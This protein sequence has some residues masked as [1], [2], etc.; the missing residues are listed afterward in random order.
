M[1]IIAAIAGC[2]IWAEEYGDSM[3]GK[4]ARR[5]P[6]KIELKR[7]A[8]DILEVAGGLYWYALYV[9]PQKEFVAQ[10]ILERYGVTTYVPV[11]R[12]WRRRNKYT[13]EKRLTS[14]PL[15][16]RYVFAGFPP[17]IP[18]WFDLFNLPLISGVVGIDDVPMRL[19][20]PDVVSLLRKH[21]NGVVA[22][23]EQKH[24]QTGKEFAVGDN[25]EVVGGP[26]DGMKAPVTSIKGSRAKLVLLD[27]IVG[28]IEFPL[29]VLQ[30]A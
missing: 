15:A 16:P 6:V 4:A 18:L 21:P 1:S 19:K 23:K 28:E 3:A 30:A 27:G 25:V 22:P 26:F 11:R 12:D 8:S 24:M 20:T 13:K 9:R 5:K 7:T 14:Y 29:E 17:G 2:F 10:I